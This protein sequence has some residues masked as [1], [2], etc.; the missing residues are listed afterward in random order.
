MCGDYDSVIGM[1]KKNVF[2]SLQRNLLKLDL[3]R[4]TERYFVWYNNKCG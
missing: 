4:L 3:S 1:K 2:K